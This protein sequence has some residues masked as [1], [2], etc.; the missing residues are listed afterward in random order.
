MKMRPIPFSTQMVKAVLD[1]TK[2]QTRRLIKPQPTKS[3][4]NKA[5][6]RWDYYFKGY[7]G[8]N[9]SSDDMKNSFFGP[10]LACK[11]GK[12]GDYLWIRE[13]WRLLAWDFEDPF[14]KVEYKDGATQMCDVYDPANDS[15]W[16]CNH[17]EKLE[18]AGIIET[19]F[20]DPDRYRFTTRDI[21]W[22]RARFMPKDFCRI[23]LKIK[24]VRVERLQDISDDDAVEEGIDIFTSPNADA[25][26]YNCY[27]R[28]YMISE[29]DADGWPYF[30]EEEYIESFASL[31]ESIN[32]PGSW[33]ENPW[34]WV[35]EF[36]K[37]DNNPFL[38]SQ[39][40]AP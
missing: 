6:D 40:Q 24:S 13:D 34:V 30:E 15:M 21:P 8:M 3:I 10:S 16:L 29:K 25:G 31:W 37:L 4:H 27:P 20:D 32:G 22:K 18:K 11:Y 36:E 12:E 5:E 23:W 28:N 33:E 9:L 7:A 19:D 35:I 38:T 14:V 1:G 2:T 26:D 39:K 17:V